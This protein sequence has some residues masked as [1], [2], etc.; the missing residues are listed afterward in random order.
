[1]CFFSN[2]FKNIRKDMVA[3]LLKSV[4]NLRFFNTFNKKQLHTFINFVNKLSLKND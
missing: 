4:K 1:M 3:F 2:T